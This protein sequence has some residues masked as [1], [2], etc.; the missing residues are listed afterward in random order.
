MM[1]NYSSHS[2]MTLIEVLVSLAII[3]LM[4]ATV[5]STIATSRKVQ[6]ANDDKARQYQ[7]IRAGLTMLEDDL[8]MAYLSLGEDTAA[9]ERRTYFRAKM[10]G[11]G[12]RLGFST[13]SHIRTSRKTRESDNS[14]VEY[15]LTDDPENPGRLALMR[16]ETRRL[17]QIPVEDIPGETW[18]SIPGVESL[19]FEFYDQTRD[20]W[21]DEWDTTTIDGQINRLPNQVKIHLI[22]EDGRKNLMH[23]TT[24]VNPKLIDAINLTPSS[25]VSSGTTGTKGSTGTTGK[26]GVTGPNIGK[27]T[28][29]KIK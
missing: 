12:I 8:T 22:V 23:F 11:P 20:E 13:F 16:R 26:T 10:D 21:L 27:T 4:T 29:S 2:G 24:I 25:N 3:A 7:L 6:Q 1:K 15:F 18:L 28:R 14:A 17:E 5:Y 9:P 19:T